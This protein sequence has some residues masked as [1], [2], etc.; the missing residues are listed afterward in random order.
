[1]DLKQ[2][3]KSTCE[4]FMSLPFAVKAAIIWLAIIVLILSYIIP[5]VMFLIGCVVSVVASIVIIIRYL[6]EY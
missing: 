3:F 5:V 4:G 6:V 1:M 2:F